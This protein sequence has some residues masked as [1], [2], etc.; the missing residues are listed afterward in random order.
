MTPRLTESWLESVADG[1]SDL[2]L[3][4]EKWP[5][6]NWRAW[7]SPQSSQRNAVQSITRSRRCI[8]FGG[9]SSGKTDVLRRL[10]ACMAIGWDHPV[11]AE[12]A[13]INGVDTT[14]L[15]KGPGVCY[16]VALSH[17]DSVR[18][19]RD[20]VDDLLAGFERH[21]RN[22]DGTD[23]ATLEIRIPGHKKP[24]KIFFRALGQGRKGFQGDQVRAIGIDEEPPEESTVSEATMRLIKFNGWLIM[25][26][27]PMLYGITWVFH[28]FGEGRTKRGW[29]ANWL[30]SYDNPHVK[31]SVLDAAF[32]VMSEEEAS[33]RSRGDL[34][35]GSGRVW[36]SFGAPHILTVAPD[37][38]GWKRYRGLDWGIR[39]PTSV[40]WVAVPPGGERAVV[41]RTL[42]VAGRSTAD[43]AT[44][45]TDAESS[46]PEIQIGWGD[47][48]ALQAIRDLRVDHDVVFWPGNNDSRASIDLIN[49]LLQIGPDGLPALQILSADL[50]PSNRVLIQEITGY[51]WNTKGDT[52]ELVNKVNDHSV[53][54]LRYVL[55]GLRGQG[56]L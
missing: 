20:V 46:D 6:A 36:P 43:V 51:S 18:Y 12:F 48:N 32:G 55:M 49:Q 34:V 54:A 56:E 7:H 39:R 8:V 3:R 25:S 21:W 38:S 23:E 45:I 11:A 41:Y 30:H 17:A 52:S 27:T 2:H 16:L 31:R 47:P 40:V 1:L 5:L 37:I 44:M 42:Y 15:P 50:E 13:R 19:H 14:D 22:K 10:I 29:E 28:Q 4:R 33:I 26:M 24:A 35:T 53:D 9:N